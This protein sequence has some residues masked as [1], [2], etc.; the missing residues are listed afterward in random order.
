[1]IGAANIARGM[2]QGRAWY[3]V[4][5]GLWLIGLGFIF[6]FHFSWPILLILIGAAMLLGYRLKCWHDDR[7]GDDEKF[8]NDWKH[9]NDEILEEKA[10]IV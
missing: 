3:S 10:K 7:D 2:A 4:S 5:G 6:L 8:K 1:M 9:K